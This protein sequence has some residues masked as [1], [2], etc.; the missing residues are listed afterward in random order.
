MGVL[1]GVLRRVVGLF[2]REGVAGKSMGYGV[3]RVGKKV[4]ILI[5][6]FLL[7]KMRYKSMTG[8]SADVGYRVECIRCYRG[9]W[10]SSKTKVDIYLSSQGQGQWTSLCDRY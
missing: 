9:F 6:I 1:M 2:Y 8:E 5:P 4:F 3:T 7:P 10:G